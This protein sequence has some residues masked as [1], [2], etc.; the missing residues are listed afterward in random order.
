M[1]DKLIISKFCGTTQ[2]IEFIM[3]IANHR[4]NLVTTY[5]FNNMESDSYYRWK[6][7]FLV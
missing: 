4:M 5:L 7:D 3:N 2:V 1:D 6:V